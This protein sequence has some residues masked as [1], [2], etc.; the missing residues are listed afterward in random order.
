M[1]LIGK[2]RPTMLSGYSCYSG[3][4]HE[5]GRSV[6]NW[7]RRED[8]SR[9]NGAFGDGAGCSTPSCLFHCAAFPA[10]FDRPTL[11]PVPG[12]TT[13]GC[14]SVPGSWRFMSD[15]TPATDKPVERS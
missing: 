1:A 2:V 10:V 6:L 14:Q 12:A 15:L 4:Y 9:L 13:D 5:D 3:K 8:H 7:C 11:T